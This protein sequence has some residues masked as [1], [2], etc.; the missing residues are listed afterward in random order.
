MHTIR[1]GIGAALTTFT[2]LA[3]GATGAHAAGDPYV[4]MQVLDELCA[5]RGGTAYNTP[6]T[7]A[8]CQE[9]RS[10]KGFELEQL[11]CAG[12]LGATFASAPSYGRPNRTTWICYPNS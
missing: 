5:A 9:A 10:N 2:L 11:V 8:R 12:L 1:I 3:G 7:I 6:Y 4:G